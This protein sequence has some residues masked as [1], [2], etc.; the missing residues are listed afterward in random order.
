VLEEHP[1][2]DQHADRHEEHDG[3]RF[4]ERQQVGAY[5]MAERRFADDQAGHERAEGERHAEEGRRDERRADRERERREHE[6]LTRS[7]MHDAAEE[8]R[9][10]VVAGEHHQ[11]G[12]EERGAHGEQGRHPGS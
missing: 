9:D 11:H 10:D 5:L 3:E 1:W 6:Q 4:A 8:P 7:Q 2:I 12:E